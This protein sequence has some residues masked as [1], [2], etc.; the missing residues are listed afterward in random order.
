MITY[1]RH[2]VVTLWAV[3]AIADLAANNPNNQTRLGNNGA[4]EA[5][6]AAIK[7]VTT[8]DAS[9]ANSVTPTSTSS[10]SIF[11]LGFLSGSPVPFASTFASAISS[12]SSTAT[13]AVPSF[14]VPMPE[15]FHDSNSANSFNVNSISKGN[16][17]PFTAEECEN[18]AKW[19]L[20]ALGNLI[21]LGKGEAMMVEE[22]GSKKGVLGLAA[23]VKN[24]ARF[25]AVGGA[26]AVLALLRKYDYNAA[27]AQ[28]GSRAVSNM[29]KSRTLTVTLLENGAID[30]MNVLLNQH[31]GNSAAE[32]WLKTAKDTLQQRKESFK[33]QP[34]TPPQY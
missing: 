6:V 1:M 22:N 7:M 30:L 18:M 10:N 3:R 9:Y 31:A 27:V 34:V 25:S 24:T 17:C 12:A 15:A 2:P 11:G 4:C 33:E 14:V 28:W 16:K 29:G 32:Y 20:W 26:E 19:L 8:E 5:L 13:S 21:Q 23:P